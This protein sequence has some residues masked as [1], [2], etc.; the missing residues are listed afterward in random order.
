MGKVFVDSGNQS[1][2]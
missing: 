1:A 2:G